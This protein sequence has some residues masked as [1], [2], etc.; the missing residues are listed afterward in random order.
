MGELI[1]RGWGPGPPHSILGTGANLYQNIIQ[2]RRKAL[3]KWG[4]GMH[5]KHLQAR[6]KIKKGI[7]FKIQEGAMSVLIIVGVY[8]ECVT[9][10]NSFSAL[11]CIQKLGNCMVL[12]T[13]YNL[14]ICLTN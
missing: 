3:M 10:I 8:F 6:S 1:W 2:G 11:S 12:E 9:T 7:Y 4:T 13:K 14:F 5:K